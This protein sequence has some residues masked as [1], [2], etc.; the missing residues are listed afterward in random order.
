MAYTGTF[1]VGSV[2]FAGPTGTPYQDNS[3]LFWDN[4]NFRL[5]IGGAIVPS[6]TLTVQGDSYLNGAASIIGTLAA[7]ATVQFA[8][9]TTGIAH[10]GVTGIVS[11]SGVNL[12]SADV[13]GVLNP[14]F[15]GTGVGNGPTS[16]ITL[17]G[18][19]VT[20]GKW[21]LTGAFDTI[22]RI[23]GATD[24]TFPTS[25]TLATVGGTVASITG[26]ANQISA[27]AS[28]GTVTLSFPNGLSIGSY[29]ATTPPSGGLIAPGQVS[30]GTSTPDANA[31]LTLVGGIFSTASGNTTN[32]FAY[33]FTGTLPAQT[34]TQP[35][36]FLLN[37]TI[38]TTINATEAAALEISATFSPGTATTITKAVG[39]R[40][41][42]GTG[43]GAGTVTTAVG[44][45]V[46]APGFGSS[47]VVAEFLGITNF[48]N[49]SQSGFSTTGVLSL[50]TPLTLS[51][52]G[53]SANLSGT[54]S[55]GGIVYSTASA[56]AIL[57][58]T[59]TAGQVLVSGSSSAPSW[60]TLSGVAV[61]TLQGTANQVLVNGTSG[62]PTS[63]AIT[64]TLPQ[65]IA[66]NSNVQFGAIT[67]IIAGNNF[68]AFT[69]SS[70]TSATSTAPF[71]FARNSNMTANNWMTIDFLNPAGNIGAL[72]GSQATVPNS[73]ADLA[74]FTSNSGTGI[75]ESGR[76]IGS[77]NLLSLVN[78]LPVTSGG[79][80]NS[81]A[82]TTGSVVFAGSSGIY[83]QDNSGFFY[84][85]T[86]NR[87]GIGN[88]AT[89]PDVIL[90]LNANS[91]ATSAPTIALSNNCYN[92]IVGAASA[93]PMI[94]LDAFGGGSN[95]FVGRSAQGTPG[96]PTQVLS[97]FLLT[98]FGCTGRDN[99]SYAGAVNAGMQMLSTEDWTSTARGTRLTLFTT[100]TGTTT[101]VD[102]L[103]ING[104]GSVTIAGAMGIGGNNGGGFLDVKGTISGS[105]AIYGGLFE[106]NLTETGTG[107]GTCELFVGGTHTIN[108]SGSNAVGLLQAFATVVATTAVSEVAVY[109]SSGASISGAAATGNCYTA[110]MTGVSA[111]GAG[112]L[113]NAYTAGFFAPTV[114]TNKTTL[115]TD[116]LSIGNLGV[117]PPTNGAL[118]KG[119]TL[120]GTTTSPTGATKL[121]LFNTVQNSSRITLAG[122]EFYQAAQTSADGPAILCGTNR[123]GNRQLW[124]ADSA[125]LTQNTTNQTVR[126]G[127]LTGVATTLIDATA[128]DGVTG[129]PLDF[130]T[131]GGNL[132]IF[133]TG[134]YGAG[135]RVLYIGNADTIPT[136]NPGSGGILYVTGGALKFRGS[137]GTV[138]NIAPA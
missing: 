123:S 41:D 35:S 104:D 19:I 72:I 14:P 126:I 43:A 103:S 109:Q 69:S 45:S 133:R 2:L 21:N 98:L 27:S 44:L 95:F 8:A 51:N 59:V 121:T 77:S 11:S 81:T 99:T 137:G 50:G 3:K 116:D 122:Q 92:H 36:F 22:F 125:N 73:S 7:G 87:L 102:R 53:T 30:F 74:F 66:T 56:L 136:T 78:P 71:L 82:F 79:T 48:G 114:G 42:A 120:I 65:S 49:A 75:I 29:Q 34:F 115:Y 89:S 67:S 127:I 54:V 112:G 119:S 111:V 38:T 130:Q 106:T 58:G 57:A 20:Q 129:L 108:G 47:R 64:L 105:G 5:S 113:T 10:I 12:D 110:K 93:S 26:T 46:V 33:T 9:L 132:A 107:S 37:P 15:G 83:T 100:I 138:T 118:I 39:M 4:T 31:V 134:S 101:I 68:E 90:T 124:I 91:A 17:G 40:I 96:S 62:T 135:S 61:T 1:I 13:V 63:G 128:T 94:M 25:G 70:T 52:G 6:N 84:D 131:S 117:T 97:G 23:T 28:T 85:N 86:N 60:A 16:T 55:N 80:G 24:V 18:A 32:G 76:F 88:F